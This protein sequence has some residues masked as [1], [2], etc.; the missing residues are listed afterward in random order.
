MN[1]SSPTVTVIIATYN[2]EQTLRY[3]VESVLWQTYKD[4]ECWVIGDCCTDSSEQLITNI[5]DPR[6]HWF[7]L[8]EN[9][10][11]Q[12]AP[13]NEGLRRASGKY[14]AYLNDDDIWLPNHL[15]E[16]VHGLESNQADFAYSM[17]ERL[18]SAVERHVDIPNYPDAARPPEAS[19]T[20]HT[21]MA[22]DTIG[23]WK[24][25]METRMNPRVEFFRAAQLAGY[26]FVLI[27]VLTVLKFGSQKGAYGKAGQQ[28]AYMALIR[29]DPQFVQKELSALL[30]QAAHQLDGPISLRQLRVQLLQ[31]IQRV[32]VKRKIE[33]GHLAFWR[34]PGQRI[35]KWRKYQGLD[36]DRLS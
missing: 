29:E 13:T 15:H 5:T 14:I 11:Y 28:A 3:A 20:L 35:K 22:I 1:A 30:V 36:T 33:P 26:S 4:F 16:L 25:P 10:G 34:K 7:N 8:P 9:S 32:L 23:Y 17:I 6:V 27:P 19:A 21:R 18:S 12:S 31:S 2:K 24:L